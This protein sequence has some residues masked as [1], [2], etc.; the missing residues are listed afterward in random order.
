[1]EKLGKVLPLGNGHFFR[2]QKYQRNRQFF[3]IDGS[4]MVSLRN[5]IG[6]RESLLPEIR[7]CALAYKLG[8]DL[9]E[10][11]S[12]LGFDNGPTYML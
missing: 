7:C 9:R 12:P 11:A 2:A 8:L 6:I 5:R 3:Y 10:Q 1:M 4:S